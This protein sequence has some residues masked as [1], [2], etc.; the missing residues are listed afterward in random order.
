MY[1]LSLDGLPSGNGHYFPGF[2]TNALFSTV[3]NCD[4]NGG[5][6]EKVKMQRHAVI[7]P[8]IN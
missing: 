3:W 1:Q 6:V 4:S 7:L 8:S 2:A 5:D